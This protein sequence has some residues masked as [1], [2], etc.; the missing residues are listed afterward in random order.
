V[1]TIHS[2]PA[3]LSR[4]YADRGIGRVEWRLGLPPIDVL[5]LRSFIAG[6]LTSTEPIDVGGAAVVPRDVLVRVL[7]SQ[8]GAEPD[9]GMVEYRRV[10]AA[11]VRGGLEAS[12]TA[13]MRIAAREEWG[14]GISYVTGVPPSVAA[15]M[16]C[17]GDARRVGVGGPEVML[18]VEGFFAE[19]RSRGLEASL[20]DGGSVTRLGVA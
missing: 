7:M 12:L 19:L 2:E 20:E 4:S 15:Q 5:R 10:S 11:G 18:P 14:N 16:L 6:G 8:G 17:R 13:E 1:Y 9:P 3:T